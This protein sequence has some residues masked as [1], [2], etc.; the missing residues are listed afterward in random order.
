MTAGKA[1]LVRCYVFCVCWLARDP[2]LVEKVMSVEVAV[3]SDEYC[4]RVADVI[5]R[6]GEVHQVEGTESHIPLRLRG[7]FRKRSNVLKWMRDFWP[8]AKLLEPLVSEGRGGR[9]REYSVAVEWVCEYVEGW[10]DYCAESLIR[11]LCLA[12]GVKHPSSGYVTMGAGASKA[13][14]VRMQA[15]GF[16]TFQDFERARQR[17][18]GGE[19]MDPGELSYA[20]CMAKLLEG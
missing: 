14:V 9:E 20:L 16:A 5:E 6:G 12:A 13:K 11:S 8:L 19:A 7:A 3:G 15:L 10:G 2:S 18:R 17:A 4:G 1:L